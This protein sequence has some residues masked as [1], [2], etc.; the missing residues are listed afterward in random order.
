MQKTTGN[1]KFNWLNKNIVGRLNVKDFIMIVVIFLVTFRGFI[2]NFIMSGTLLVD[3]LF[4]IIAILCVIALFTGAVNKNFNR[5]YLI[6]YIFWFA[7]CCINALWQ[8]LLNKTSV[9]NALIGIRTNNVYTL[10]ILFVTIFCNREDIKN[11]YKLF[12]NFGIIICSFAIFQFLGRNW[13]PEN[14]LIL[15]GEDIFTLYESGIIRVTGLMGN[16]IIF[17]GYAVVLFSLVWA[18]L[19]VHSFRPAILWLKIAIIVSA[20]MLTF[21]RAS[22]VGMVGV[23]SL[24]LLIFGSARGKLLKYMLTML[25]IILIALILA[26]TVF[27]D[28]VIVQRIFGFNSSWTDGSDE[29]HFTMIGDAINAIKQ[30]WLFGTMMGVSN[31]IIT[32]GSFWAYIIEWGIPVFVVYCVLICMLLI[33]ALKNLKRKDRWAMAINIGYVGMNAYFFVFSFINSAYASRSI[34]VF[35]WLIAGMMLVTSNRGY[36]NINRKE[37]I[38]KV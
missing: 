32:D 31:E 26:L 6:A 17:G 9:Y 38:N 22:V 8:V 29:G 34:L 12:I 30:N 18:E 28:S 11:Y 33:R 23:M 15:N 21:S 7:I 3:C 5:K 13:L 4:V 16:T 25:A 24:E 20:N 19:I 2:D 14:L 10:L 36:E 1:N 27:R 35:V 37:I